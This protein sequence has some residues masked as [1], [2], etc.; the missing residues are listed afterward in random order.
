MNNILQMPT[1]MEALVLALVN[2][3]IHVHRPLGE[4]RRLPVDHLEGQNT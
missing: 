4:E 3:F 1:A 2:F